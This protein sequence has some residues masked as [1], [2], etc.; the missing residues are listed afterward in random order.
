MATLLQAPVHERSKDA[1]Y[2]FFKASM[3]RSVMKIQFIEV[4]LQRR[5]A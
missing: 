3:D 1:V 4:Y 5:R 2:M